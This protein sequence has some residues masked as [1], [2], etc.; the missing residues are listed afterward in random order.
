M[1]HM[2]EVFPGFPGSIQG[3]VGLVCFHGTSLGSVMIHTKFEVSRFNS[4]AMRKIL[5]SPYEVWIGRFG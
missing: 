2:P 4:F 5:R 3:L 1:D